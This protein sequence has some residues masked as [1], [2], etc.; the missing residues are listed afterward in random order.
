MTLAEARARLTLFDLWRR[1]DLPGEPKVLSCRCPFHDDTRASFS[2]SKDGLLWNCFAGCGGGDAIDFL[3]RVTG[4]SRG[5]ACKKFIEM[6]G[7]SMEIPSAR[8]MPVAGDSQRRER[9]SFP[10]FERGGAADFRKLARLRNLS[11]EGI[12][13]ASERG[14]LWFAEL[15]GFESWLVADGE[16]VN[17]QARRLDGGTWG[18]LEGSPKTWTLYGSWAS[19]PIGTGE[20][21]QFKTVA[22]VEGGGDL[23]AAFHF[24]HCEDREDDVAPVAILGASQRIPED[25]LQL[26][27][28]KRIRLY[29]HTDTAGHRAE[30]R[31]TQQLEA[32]GAEV[33]AFGFDDL[34][35]MDGADVGDLNDLAYISADVRREAVARARDLGVGER[36][37]AGVE[38][39]R[40]FADIF[41]TSVRTGC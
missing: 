20:A 26:L 38:A 5:G 29:P 21:Q 25:A 24:I 4:L 15:H 23:L 27:A 9:P 7:G 16:R 11:I 32:V 33:D 22:L 36:E 17:V 8:R 34:R 1:F 31:W 2:I 6:A 30:A 18:H 35:R 3:Q 39:M 37:P 19:W 14:L 13:L 41:P 28:G 10:D 12:Q 40:T